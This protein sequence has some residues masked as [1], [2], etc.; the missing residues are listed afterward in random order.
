MN[1]T[2]SIGEWNEDTIEFDEDRRSYL[3]NGERLE[4]GAHRVVF[5]YIDVQTSGWVIVEDGEFNEQTEKY[6]GTMVSSADYWG[7]F[8]E[9]FDRDKEGNIEV[10]I[11]S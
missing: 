3:K 7:V 10:I 1:M 2:W 11:G 4:D 9:G 6:I 5:N 8:I